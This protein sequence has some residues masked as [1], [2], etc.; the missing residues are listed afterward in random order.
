MG[1]SAAVPVLRI[2]DE[3]KARAFYLDFLGF[4]VEWEHRFEEGAPLYMQ[5]AGD[6]C[7]LHLSEHHGD[8]SPGAAVRIGC[9]ALDAF[10]RMLL[11]KSYPHARPGIESMPWGTREMVVID[12]FANRLIFF[13]EAPPK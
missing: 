11:A 5:L 6:R 8:C 1:F 2:F 9:D 3:A 4:Q 13:E 7:V 12:P 10:H